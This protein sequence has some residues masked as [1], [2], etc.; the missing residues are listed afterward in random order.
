MIKIIRKESTPT[1][2]DMIKYTSHR[3]ANSTMSSYYVIECK[4]ITKS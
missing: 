4:L 2:I 3:K 1:T